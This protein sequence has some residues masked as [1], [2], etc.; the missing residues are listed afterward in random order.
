[1]AL[2]H[3]DPFTPSVR[4]DTK[5]A[6]PSLW[7]ATAS[8]SSEETWQ[9]YNQGH[10]QSR[11]LLPVFCFFVIPSLPQSP[12]LASVSGWRFF[13]PRFYEALNGN[14]VVIPCEVVE[15]PFSKLL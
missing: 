10:H 3:G 1:M 11:L 13:S 4:R 5:K 7:T 6:V 14:A 9:S 8:M 15:I 2:F 12:G